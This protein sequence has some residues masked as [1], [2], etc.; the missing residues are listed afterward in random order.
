MELM[1]EAGITSMRSLL[2]WVGVQSQG[3]SLADANWGAFDREVE[4]A[5]EA[6][7][8]VMPVVWGSPRM[9]GRRPG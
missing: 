4:L 2:H 3:P 1:R 9:G 7:I 6:G 8:R 5:A